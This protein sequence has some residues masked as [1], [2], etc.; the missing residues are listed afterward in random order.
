MSRSNATY[1]WH[2][3]CALEVWDVVLHVGKCDDV[4]GC[5]YVVSEILIASCA[6]S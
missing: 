1:E 5:V 2:D 6:Q 4:V 3:I